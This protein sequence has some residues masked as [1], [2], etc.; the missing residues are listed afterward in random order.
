[1]AEQM[2]G[3]SPSRHNRHSLKH[4]PQPPAAYASRRRERYYASRS[5]AARCSVVQG[6]A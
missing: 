1:M 3:R 2:Q 5:D 6:H 4:Q